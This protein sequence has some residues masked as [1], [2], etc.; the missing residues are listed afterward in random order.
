MSFNNIPDKIGNIFICGTYRSG[1]TITEKVLNNHDE[2]CVASQ[3][4]PLLFIMYKEKFNESMNLEQRYPLDHKFLQRYYDGVDF[5]NFL[6]KNLFRLNDISILKEKMASYIGL[7]TPEILD[8][9]DML[10]EGNFYS[11]YRQFLNLLYG[12]YGEPNHKYIGSKEVLFEEYIPVLLNKGVKT[13]LVVRDPRDMIASVNFREI[14]NQ[15]GENRPILYSLRNWRKS[16]AY[17][18]ELAGH[19]NF[20]SIQYEDL[21]LK[22]EETL[23]AISVFLNISPFDLTQLSKG[24][25]DQNGKDWSGNSAFHKHKG[26]SAK[27]IGKYKSKLPQE[28]IAYIE[29]I[30]YPEMIYLKYERSIVNDYSP[31][32]IKSYR[33]P[34][35]KIHSS[36]E[37]DY[38][39]QKKRIDDEIKRYQ[40]LKHKSCPENQIKDWFIFE[41]VYS[42]LLT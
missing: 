17:S 6:E 41:K 11:I 8:K 18:I 1:T 12:L 28:V 42:E 33:D 29:T 37:F 5:E 23:D 40:L 10:E 14:D 15:T 38:S 4:F 7:W 35:H 39:Q 25:K 32:I 26:I 2:L 20:L 22:T 30:C 13:I 34:F 36:F 21:V 3:P 19:E 16:I 9:M 24:I 31:E 27:S